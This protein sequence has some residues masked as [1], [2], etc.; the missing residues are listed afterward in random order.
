MALF[1][2]DPES[3]RVLVFYCH[4]D[5]WFEMEIG[6]LQIPPPKSNRWLIL[7]GHKGLE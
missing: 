4:S 6:K 7:V 3:E 2:H 5:F 1:V